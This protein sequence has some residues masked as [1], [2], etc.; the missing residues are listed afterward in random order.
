[1]VVADEDVLQTALDW[2]ARGKKVAIATLVETW[3][4]APRPVGSQLVV[5]GDG[6]FVGSISGGCIE[7]EVITQALDVIADGR[8]RMC[9][10]G[11][12]NETAWQAGLSCG[13]RIKIFVERV[14]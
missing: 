3:G 13:G 1:M 8:H 12:S 11:V 14:D 9:E 4:S 6:Q 2:H 5:D 7:A 10:F